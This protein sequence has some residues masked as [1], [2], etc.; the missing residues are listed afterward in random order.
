V[1]PLRLL[2]LPRLLPLALRPQLPLLLRS[3]PLLLSL[4]LHLLLRPLLLCLHLLL[5]LL[6]LLLH[7]H[8]L[9]LLLLLLLRL[10]LH[11]A[12][13]RVPIAA[14]CITLHLIL[15]APTLSIAGLHF[16]KVL[17]GIFKF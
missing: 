16:R 9:L 3:L 5:L 10:R 13:P 11:L 14:V 7:L 17:A 4:P 15:R 8:L 12:L 2:M 6:L 1:V